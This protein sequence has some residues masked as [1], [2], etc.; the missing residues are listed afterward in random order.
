MG[1]FFFFQR[2]TN[3]KENA[4]KKILFHEYENCDKFRSGRGRVTH[5]RSTC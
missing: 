1:N 2:E 4:K 3:S 5:N